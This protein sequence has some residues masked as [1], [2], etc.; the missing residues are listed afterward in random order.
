MPSKTST[1]P[2]VL[3][4]TEMTKR[5]QAF[6]ARWKGDLGEEQR[7]SQ[8]FWNQL[9]EVFGVDR[10]STAVFERRAR[11]ASTGQ[12]GRID[13]FMPGVMIAEQKSL[14]RDLGKADSQAEDY[15][16][17]G[18]ILPAEMPR[19]VV[20]SDFHDIQITDL[21]SPADPPFRFPVSKLPRHISR[22][23]FLSG[24]A[25]PKRQLD[26]QH[27][28]TVKAARA[29]GALYE[30]LLGDIDANGDD[31]DAEQAA[32]FM[33]RLLFLLFGDDADGLW[34]NGAFETF[35]SEMTSEDGS[36]TGAQIA[37]LFQV[38]N[39][40]KEKRSPRLDTR[41]AKL[42]YVNGGIFQANVDIPT[43]DSDMRKALLRACDEDW[44]KVS[45]A[46]FGSLFQ[47]MSSRAQRRAHG[48]HYT[49]EVN[50]L[51]TLR[52]LFLDELEHRLQEA[53]NSDAALT[54]L[55]ESF[56]DMRYLDPA[57]GSGN[58]LI[59]AYREMRDIELRLLVRLREL[60]GESQMYA[61][62]ATWGLNVTPDQFGGIEINWWPSKIAETAM[63]LVDHQANQR[64]A[65]TLGAAPERLP[66]KVAAK[67]VHDN[68]LRADWNDVFPATNTTLVFGNPPFLGDNRE[69]DQLADLQAAWGQ[70]SLSRLDF[71]TGWH[72]KSID[73]L[74]DARD[75]R[76]AFVTTNS[77]TQGDQVRLL[78]PSILNAGWKIAFAHRTFTW[79]SEA[80]GAAAVHCVIVGFARDPKP[81]RLFDYSESRGLPEEVDVTRL[82]PY[83][84]DAPDI[85]VEKL[86]KPLS[87]VLGGAVRGSMATDGG[88]L[89]VRAED[90]AEVA[91]DPIASKYLRRFY[92]AD[93][94]INGTERW[95]LWFA[96]A[97]PSELVTSP[98]IRKRLE[99]VR[100][101]RLASK[102]ET[103]RPHADTP[104]SSCSPSSPRRRT[105]ASLATSASRVGTSPS[106][107]SAPMSSRATPTSLRSIPMASCS[108]PSL[109]P[110]SRRGRRPSGAA[111][112]RTSASP[113][114]SHG[115]RSPS[116]TS[117]TLTG[118]ASSRLAR[119]SSPP[120]GSN[121]ARVSPTSTSRS[122]WLA[123]CWMPTERST[124][125]WTRSSASPSRPP[126]RSGRRACSSATRR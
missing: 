35:I 64:M 42:P 58:F 124:R 55:H 24:Y 7:S 36:D 88:H 12:D 92:G 60:R 15:L 89:M 2:K 47:G 68:A 20:S 25:A 122:G 98:L 107:T 10:Y 75:A 126:S 84:V 76:F 8:T 65:E 73:Y 9:F 118:S 125:P 56:A 105:S 113:A 30:A 86:S 100:D 48:E 62:D 110:C 54:R 39:T 70:K 53:W 49:T 116:R 94:L 61:I 41:L 72:A 99:A 74:K 82:N 102:A 103:T 18:D 66:I 120:D 22:F 112:S 121:Q 77:I 13:V 108:P 37:H 91:A 79:T 114:P 85:F 115:T 101:M 123:S 46:I 34:E 5:A 95:V 31:H 6:T 38:L 96:D 29:M 109:P 93:E 23:A 44:S 43:F 90:Y 14:G 106:A 69:K 27:E 104:T 52:P 111:S 50:I 19:F 83:L 3:S 81:V 21:L 51:K 57:C 4:S 45:P 17:G 78:F 71:V 80:T 32:I 40:P 28:V 16:A 59:V 63:F 33:T 97:D 117:A 1:K 26:D 119:A 67:I 11:R 87:P